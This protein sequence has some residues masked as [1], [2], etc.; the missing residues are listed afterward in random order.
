MKKG[1]AKKNKTN[2]SHKTKKRKSS[3]SHK[4]IKRKHSS[5][6]I[7]K[8]TFTSSKSLRKNNVI[9]NLEKNKVFKYGII[10]I[11]LLIAALLISSVVNSTGKV[12]TGNI[13]AGTE[14]L[15]DQPVPDIGK[16]ILTFLNGVG[17]NGFTEVTDWKDLIVLVIVFAIILVAIYDILSLLA[18]F[19]NDWVNWTI[20]IGLAI[21]AALTGFIRQAATFLFQ[22]GAGLFAF[23][24]G[25]EIVVVAILFIGLIFGSTWIAKFAAKRKGQREYIRS[26]GGSHSAEAGIRGL[27]ALD[28]EFRM[29]NG[30]GPTGGG[31]NRSGPRGGT[32]PGGI[33]GRPGRVGG[34]G[35]PP[36][37]G[38]PTRPNRPGGRFA[39]GGRRQGPTRPTGPIGGG[40]AGAGG[41]NNFGGGQTGSGSAGQAGSTKSGFNFFR[42]KQ[43]KIV[44]EE[45][46]LLEG[47]KD[48]NF[49]ENETESTENNF[50]EDA[51]EESPKEK[52]DEIPPYE[53]VDLYKRLGVGKESTRAEIKSAF[54]EKA[55]RYHPDQNPN[56]PKANENFMAI[57]KAYDI[58]SSIADD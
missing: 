25:L 14:S 36:S 42:S 13:P 39:M 47:P 45:R 33:G 19:Y 52:V 54:R 2:S 11:A 37:G 56:D 50:K 3:A 51:K 4:S 8:K 38:G 12:I 49:Y 55:K 10:V 7:V 34:A 18:L 16:M 53:E 28:R 9:S 27:K 6:K 30:N 31:P 40:S 20:A 43:N 21:I 23:A 5:H 46:L 44:E 41:N 22:T 15:L 48:N 1:K 32:G 57:Q 26:I 29:G 17:S 35:I 58:L 24:T